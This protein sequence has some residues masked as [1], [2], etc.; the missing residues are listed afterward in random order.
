MTAGGETKAAGQLRLR[1]RGALA[2]AATGSI[3]VVAAVVASVI[4]VVVV[5]AALLL[6]RLLLRAVAWEDDIAVDAARSG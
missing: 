2:G 5:G 3:I 1:L 6:L 4:A